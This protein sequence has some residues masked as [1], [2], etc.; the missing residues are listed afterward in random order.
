MPAAVLAFHGCDAAIGRR[1]LAG[2]VEHLAPSE[3]AYDWLG[4]GIY[5]WE[6]DPWRA[7]QWA[8]AAAKNRRLTARPVTE[9]YV[10]GA[11][12]DLGH[13]CNLLDAA[14][15]AEALNASEF[16]SRVFQA[17]MTPFPENRGGPDRILRF[18]DRAVI[19]AIHGLR[20]EAG[21]R[22]YDS[23]RAVFPEGEEL[24]PGAG[25]RARSH[26]QV[27]VRNP[28]CIKGYF[29]LPGL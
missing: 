14:S 4:T 6:A 1:L 24:Y 21:Q 10:V 26:I 23:M 19:E 2:R 28:D 5:F 22:P 3:N 13:C 18:R 15:C 11:M 12:I 29:R 25:F 7:L 17:S 9:P 8:Q 27:A 16:I 20:E